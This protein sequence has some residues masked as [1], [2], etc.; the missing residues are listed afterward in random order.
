ML[1]Y[2]K[3]NATDIILAVI[4]GAFVLRFALEIIGVDLGRRQ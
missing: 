1:E 3:A 4:T 2:L